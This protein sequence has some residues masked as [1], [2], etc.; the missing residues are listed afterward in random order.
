MLD[1]LGYGQ[2]SASLCRLTC[3]RCLRSSYRVGGVRKLSLWPRMLSVWTP[4]SGWWAWREDDERIFFVPVTAFHLSVNKKLNLQRVTHLI[5]GNKNNK[6]QIHVAKIHHSYARDTPLF[7]L[8]ALVWQILPVSSWSLF[9]A[10]A[11]HRK[12]Y[13]QNYSYIESFMNVS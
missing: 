13:R 7:Y 6:T 10:D 3:F 11:D 1:K 9:D 5:I 12:K 4:Q 8:L 2:G